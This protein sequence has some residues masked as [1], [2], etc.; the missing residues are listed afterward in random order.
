M[1]A[2]P[3]VV[4][5][6][7]AV[8]AYLRGE[9]AGEVVRDLLAGAREAGAALP[10]SVVNWGEVVYVTMRA[11][12]RE[13]AVRVVA[14]LD[15]LPVAVVDAD[16]D[17]TSRAAM[18]KAEHRLSYADACAAALALAL[19]LPLLTGDPEFRALEPELALHWIGE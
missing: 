2:G 13:D 15:G 1:S 11:R 19:D 17:L 9:A 7:W 12:G 3:A 5:D 10:L 16:R 14:A 8:M 18:L 6:A 4:L